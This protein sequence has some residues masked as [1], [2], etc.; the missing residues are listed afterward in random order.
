[1]THFSGQ[2]PSLVGIDIAQLGLQGSARSPVEGGN[3]PLASCDY[4]GRC[5]GVRSRESPVSGGLGL[6]GGA[7]MLPS[8]HLPVCVSGSPVAM[9]KPWETVCLTFFLARSK[10]ISPAVKSSLAASSSG[11]TQTPK[12]PG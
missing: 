9:E 2:N 3:I 5:F 8:A 4:F 1:M 6:G 10:G 7:V 12:R 11:V